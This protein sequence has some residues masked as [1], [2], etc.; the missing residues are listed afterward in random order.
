MSHVYTWFDKI[1]SDFSNM[2]SVIRLLRHQ[3]TR[4]PLFILDEI[5]A[6]IKFDCNK[7]YR[8]LKTFRSLFNEGLV[9]IIISGYEELYHEK[10]KIDSPLY[11]FCHT[12]H[13]DKLERNEALDLV[14]IPME[15]IGVRYHDPDDRDL[16]LHHTSRH[17]N[18]LQFFCVQLIERI[19]SHQQE[20]YQRVIF[21]EDIESVFESSEYENYIIDDFYLLFKEDVSPI[22]KLIVLLLINYYP[23]QDSFTAIEINKIL[24]EKELSMPS[25]KLTKYLDNL[26]LRY[27]FTKERGG[28]Y[29]FALPIFPELLMRRYD[30]ENII[31]GVLED[32][33]KSL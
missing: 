8:L 28:K 26:I 30:L 13:L 1:S 23:E 2:R 21:R 22:E 14:T 20:E 3:T 16:V 10:H 5:D 31:E 18:L 15:R 7:D 24:K 4:T 33:R 9:H 27:I 12:L 17:P 25:G 11:N 32:A 29:S 6:L 19:E